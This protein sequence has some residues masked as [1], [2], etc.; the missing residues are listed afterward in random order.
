MIKVKF[1]RL[2]NVLVAKVLEQP[3]ETGGVETLT[4][5]DDYY[6]HSYEQPQISNRTLYLRGKN[7]K[8]DDDY[9]AYAYDNVEEAKE[10][11]NGFRKC[12][13]K[14]NVEHCDKDEEPEIETVVVG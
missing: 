7:K 10:A 14:Y 4:E 9:C 2:G 11:L 1:W 8:H 13:E 6:I 5:V 3:E 12:I